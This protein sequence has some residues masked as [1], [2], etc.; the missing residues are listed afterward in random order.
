MVGTKLHSGPFSAS[1]PAPPFSLPIRVYWED[2]D[3]GGV[4]YH[5]SYLRFLERVRTEWLLGLGRGQQQL[6][7]SEDLVLAVRE[8]RI[9]YLKPARLDDELIATV[10][11]IEM[12][13]ASFSMRQTIFRGDQ[14]L[15]TAD[16]RVACLVASE[17]KPRALPD[18]L[19][20]VNS[21]ME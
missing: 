1:R 17:L 20:A 6:R 12:R 10:D 4:V 11:A 19:L 15:L 13:R 16:V 18:W 9:D 3:A 2:T 7:E 5:A 21:K 8:L 14:R